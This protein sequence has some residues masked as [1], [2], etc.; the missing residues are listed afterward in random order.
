M[1]IKNNTGPITEPCGTPHLIGSI[2][3][4]VLLK[5]LLLKFKNVLKIVMLM[6]LAYNL[7][8]HFYFHFY[9]K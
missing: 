6:I 2:L 5:F 3:E 9:I 7:S 8:N 4:L 1:Y